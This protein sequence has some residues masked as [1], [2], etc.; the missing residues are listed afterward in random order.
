MQYRAFALKEFLKIFKDLLEVM[1]MTLN[2]HHELPG[3]FR[4]RR[5]CADSYY[6]H[7]SFNCNKKFIF[8]QNTL[9]LYI[10]IQKKI[11]LLCTK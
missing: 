2:R 3:T 6:I 1:S 11:I 4:R 7:H 10:D 8:R 5:R 9:K